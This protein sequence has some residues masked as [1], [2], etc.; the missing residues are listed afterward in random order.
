MDF[1]GLEDEDVK[2]D[3]DKILTYACEHRKRSFIECFS[4]TNHVVFR[5]QKIRWDLATKSWLD[6][7]LIH[8]SQLHSLDIL[9]SYHYLNDIRNEAARK[10]PQ[11]LSWLQLEIVESADEEILTCFRLTL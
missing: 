11:N 10:V 8:R 2:F 9:I 5:Q 1:L 7:T 3:G 6:E 4:P